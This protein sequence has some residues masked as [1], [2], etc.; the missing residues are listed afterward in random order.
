M[1]VYIRRRNKVGM[2]KMKRTIV[3]KIITTKVKLIRRR[4]RRAQDL[5]Y[6][7]INKGGAKALPS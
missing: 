4:G 2:K 7:V 1:S 6:G 3:R 5:P